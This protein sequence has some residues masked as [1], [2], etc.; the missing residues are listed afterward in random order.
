MVRP[1]TRRPA[2]TAGQRSRRAVAFVAAVGACWASACGGPV[3][4]HAAGSVHRS[5]GAVTVAVEAPLSGAEAATGEDLWRGAQLAAARLDGAGGVAGRRIDLVAADDRGDPAA[6]A[7]VARQLVA[8]RVAAVVGPFDPG[9]ADV[10][11]PRYRQ[12][13]IPVVRLTATDPGALAGATTRPVVRQLAA[14]DAQELEQVLHVHR[15]AVLRSADPTAAALVQDL[16]GLLG[17][18]GVVVPVSG[19]LAPG[20]DPAGA[21]AQVAGGAVDAVVLAMEVPQAA[22]LVAAAAG[23]LGARCLVSPPSA[24]GAAGAATAALAPCL[25]AGVPPLAELPGGAAYARAYQA[26]FGVPPGPW[27]VFAYDAVVLLAA[28]AAD[29]GSWDAPRLAALLGP[30]AGHPALPAV[31]GVPVRAPGMLAPA[32]GPIVLDPATGD[33]LAPPLAVLDVS[34]AGGERVDAAWQAYAGTAVPGE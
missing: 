5:P 22:G 30:V 20:A 17:S 13:G 9:V 16:T 25:V 29:V 12:A 27:G 24:Q 11:L 23:R 18:S 19:A 28:A 21:L 26:R 2:A 14:V 6:A 1:L 34:P 32:T 8:R 3:T 7:T 10:V 31:D 4:T 15:V 33:R